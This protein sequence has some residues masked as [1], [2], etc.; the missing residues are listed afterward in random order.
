MNSILQSQ[1]FKKNGSLISIYF[2][3][4]I[5]FW[6]I[7]LIIIP[8]LYMLDLSFRPNLP[9]LLRGGADDVHTLVHYKHFLFAFIFWKKL[10]L[11]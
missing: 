5:V 6:L 8:Q 3:I 4:A 7:F 9:P 10:F 1:F 11:I 2:I